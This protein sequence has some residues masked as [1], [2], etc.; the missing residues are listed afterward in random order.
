MLRFCDKKGRARCIGRPCHAAGQFPAKLFYLVRLVLLLSHSS[1]FK[2]FECTQKLLWRSENERF[3]EVRLLTTIPGMQ[4]VFFE[5]MHIFCTG[6]VIYETNTWFSRLH[7]F[8]L[9]LKVRNLLA[10]NA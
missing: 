8:W 7:V 5:F 6:I 1:Y 9:Q 10:E 2:V 3:C 4:Y